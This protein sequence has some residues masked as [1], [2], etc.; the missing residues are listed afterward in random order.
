MLLE[1]HL[2]ISQPHRKHLGTCW[3]CL[4]QLF[5][6]GE[7]STNSQPPHQSGDLGQEARRVLNPAW[8]W[9]RKPLCLAESSPQWVA[10]S[11]ALCPGK[12]WGLWNYTFACRYA[13][14]P[15]VCTTISVSVYI[16]CHEGKFESLDVFVVPFSQ[17]PIVTTSHLPQYFLKSF[18]K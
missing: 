10:L 18:C 1:R 6:P 8:E 17:C 12:A 5:A 7:Q 16:L 11:T 15:L 3:S 14:H 9:Q 4:H 13:G 2:Y